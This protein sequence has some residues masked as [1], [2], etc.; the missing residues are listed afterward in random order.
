MERACSAL[1]CFA[2]GDAECKLKVVNHGA[3]DAVTVA[4]R[5]YPKRANVVE[6]GMAALMQVAIPQTVIL[7]PNCHQRLGLRPG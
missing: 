4:M 5:A 7:T 3:I 2:E 6:R 1:A